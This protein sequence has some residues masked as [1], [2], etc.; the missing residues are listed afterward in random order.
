MIYIATHKMVDFPKTEWYKTL[1]LGGFG[2]GIL[3]ELDNTGDNIS[4]KNRNY[5]ELTGLYWIWKNV[6]ADIVGICH[7]RRYFNL[8]PVDGPFARHLSFER[9]S[10]IKQI[11]EHPY[12]LERMHQILDEYDIILPSALLLP[13]SVDAK[14]KLDHSSMEWEYF[15]QILDEKHGSNVHSLRLDRRLLSNN[16][17]ICKKSL[18]DE[19]A[20][21]LFSIIDKVYDHFGDCP[22]ELNLRYQ[23]FRYPGYL[24]ER[25]MTA[26]VNSMKLKYY[27]AQIFSV[28]N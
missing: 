22:E 6:R 9:F 26:F 11:L 1:G 25:F 12:Q 13:V 17:M 16:M 5:C 19:Y 20:E 21:Q 18:F 15:M 23:R 4:F 8:I 14:Y 7:Y 24:A 27:D 28:E 2:A 3:D 10:D